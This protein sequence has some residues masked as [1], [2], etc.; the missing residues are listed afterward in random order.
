MPNTY[1]DDAT[2]YHAAVNDDG[3]YAY[4]PVES[5]IPEGWRDAGMRGTL[6]EV[7]AWIDQAP[8]PSPFLRRRAH[9][10]GDE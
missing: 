8:A 6:K 5:G 9:Q 2:P 1:A 10:D 7:I 3:D 4:F